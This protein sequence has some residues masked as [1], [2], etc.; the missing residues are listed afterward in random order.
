MDGLE[1][2]WGVRWQPPPLPP[3]LARTGSPV[4]WM[5]SPGPR[6]CRGVTAEPLAQLGLLPSAV[7]PSFPAA[8]HREPVFK[9]TY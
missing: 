1:S 9:N 6:P 5:G 2:P 8:P 3:A 7:T 4:L